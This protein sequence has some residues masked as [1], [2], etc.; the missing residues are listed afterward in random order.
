MNLF[1]EIWL[2][3]T[4]ELR[5]NFRSV[6]GIALGIISLL[7]GVAFGAFQAI[8]ESAFKKNLSMLDSMEANVKKASLQQGLET[9][10]Y[11]TEVAKHLVEGPLSLHF[12]GMISLGFAPLLASILGFDTIAND[13]QHR[14]IRYW[15]MRTS[16]VGYLFGKLLGLWISVSAVMTGIH[17]IAWL[18]CIF[19]GVGP[20]SMILPWGMQFLLST[21]WVSMVW[22]SLIVLVSS[23]V[24]SS[25][26]SLILG[27]AI[28]FVLFVVKLV[29]KVVEGSEMAKDNASY[30][31]PLRWI[32]P[33]NYDDLLYSAEPKT[34]AIGIMALLVFG[35]LL[36][37]ASATI[38]VKRDV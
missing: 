17:V 29:I 4:R 37:S 22:C 13:I 36:S 2:I 30:Q 35:G 10:G 6:K 16:R 5:R 34:L 25:F 27:S 12:L 9:M 18:V 15:T 26:W 28:I 20:A 32:Y 24:R 11:Q 7:G 3:C 31:F 23:M 14:T 21:L 1:L 38:L 19:T 8:Q 33:N